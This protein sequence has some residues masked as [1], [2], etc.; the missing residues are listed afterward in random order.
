MINVENIIKYES[1]EMS[2]KEMVLFFAKLIK[3]GE[4]WSLQGHYGRNAMAIIEAG[5]VDRE[6]NI[7]EDMLNY[8][9]EDNE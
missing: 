5:I 9:T 6:G 7:D 3:S 8:Y 4:A 1:G 2:L